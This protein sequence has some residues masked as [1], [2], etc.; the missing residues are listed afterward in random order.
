M[1]KRKTNFD[2][3]R[4]FTMLGVILFHHFGTKMPNNFVRLTEG[5]SENTYFYDFINNAAS[6]TVS[7]LSLLMDFCYGHFGNGGNYIFMMITGYFLFGRKISFPKRIRT[8]GNILFA[9]LY[10]G[11]ILTVINFIVF[12]HYPFSHAPS[13]RPLFTLPNWLGGANLWY[14][15]AYGVFILV[16][17]PLLKLFEEKL[18]K[19]THLCL[20]VALV[21]INFLAYQTYLPN[22]WIS[23]QIMN[24]I[25]WYYIGGYISKYKVSVSGKKL[26]IMSAVYVVMYFAYEYY[27]RLSCSVMWEPSEY[28]Y[29]DVMQPFICC[30]IYASLCFLIFNNINITFKGDKI[31]GFLTAVSASTLGIYVFHYNMINIT[32]L[33][34]DTFWWHDWSRKGYFLFCIIDSIML[35]VIGAVLDIGRRKGYKY[36]TTIIEKQLTTAE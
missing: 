29:I 5:F 32:F 21:F 17:L 23:F 30:L 9:L 27:W 36:L 6:G 16:I 19:Q 2:L 18:T 26:L 15:Q 24:F 33:L 7:K 28:S 12:C 3:L 10:Y 34:G 8:V 4:I 14:V 35:F 1:S 13:F 25:M 20:A 11:I 22:L 31:S